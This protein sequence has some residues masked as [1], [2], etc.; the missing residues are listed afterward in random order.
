[1]VGSSRFS[2]IGD[3]TFQIVSD[4]RPDAA[5]D[6]IMMGLHMQWRAD[7]EMILLLVLEHPCCRHEPGNTL[8]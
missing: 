3:L 7:A 8:Q 6:R 1:M 2:N 5:M 4:P